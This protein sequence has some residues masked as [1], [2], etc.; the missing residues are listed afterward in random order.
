M[1]AGS[2]DGKQKTSRL[3]VKQSMPAAE[4]SLLDMPNKTFL[5]GLAS[6]VLSA[7]LAGKANTVDS[8]SCRGIFD[9]SVHYP[10]NNGFASQLHCIA[11]CK[12]RRIRSQ[13]SNH[14][15]LQ[16]AVDCGGPQK[17]APG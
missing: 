8:I 13:N 11:A 7:S 14:L 3:R 15:T 10:E 5:K 16:A 1:N 12:C 17:M 6:A 2:E 9:R 4:G